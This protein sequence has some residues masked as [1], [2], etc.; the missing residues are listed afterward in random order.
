L[1]ATKR[2]ELIE[3]YA[4]YIATV[5]AKYPSIDDIEGAG[6]LGEYYE[7]LTE[8]R[9]LERI[10]RCESDLA[11]FAIE[12]F[13]EHGNPENEGNWDGFEASKPDDLAQFH[14]ELTAVMNDLSIGNRAAK[15]AQAVSR[16][17]GKSTWLSKGFPI[18]EIVYRSRRYILLISETPDV[19]KSNLEW[20]RTQLKFNKKLREDFGPLLSPKDQSNIVDN[21]DTFIAWHPDGNESKKQLTLVQAVSSGQALRG[22]NWNNIRPDLIIM[23]DLE[24]ASTGKNASTP[25]Q[26]RALRN[27]FTQSVMPLGDPRGLK[28]AYV[29]MGT[30]VHKESLLMHILHDRPDFKTKIYRALIE[31]PVNMSL[32]DKCREIYLDRTRGEKRAADALAYYEANKEAM[33]EGAKVLWEEAQPIY[34]LRTWKFANGSLAFNTEYQ[35]NPIDEESMLF[36]PEAFKYYD[37]EIDTLSD[38]YDV[39]F[40]VDMAMGKSRTRGDY[41][42]VTVLAKEK[43]T[44]IIYVADSYGER[45]KPDEF[46]S[47]IVELVRK[48]QPQTIAVESQLAQEFFA[49]E[50][51]KALTKIGY[52]AEQRLKKIFQRTR[53]ELR[54]EAMI[55]DIENETIQF[56]SNHSLLLEQF[57]GYGQGSHDDLPDSMS[58]AL[59]A[60][61][62]GDVSITT[63]RRMNRW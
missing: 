13:S 61:S 19:A 28:T 32:W 18:K 11:E 24:D 56:N 25:E 29:V 49:D 42:A 37:G 22:R 12:Y 36:N 58:M 33:D 51:K 16:G 35:N 1:N 7:R 10:Q 14:K 4:E 3:V 50:L 41:S 53:K 38:R 45:I 30:T 23:D 5:D 52:P 60:L 20:I 6:L 59:S 31:P 47:I 27:W 17:H 63:V 55:P 21:G 2:K 43:E 15:I 54:I 8:L 26:R 9:R 44:G 46:I 62:E 57:E 39:S 40:G 34:K 48:H